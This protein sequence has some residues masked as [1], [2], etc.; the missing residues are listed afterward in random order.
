MKILLPLTN[1]NFYDGVFVG[2]YREKFADYVTKI[3][4]TGNSS[5]LPSLETRKDVITALTE[6]YI[7]QA[8]EQPNGVQ[9][10][11]LANWLLI[12]DLTNNH[13]DKVTLTEYPF[14][15]NRQLR[16]RYRREMANE[17]LQYTLTEQEYLEG[18]KESRYID[19]EQYK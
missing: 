12:E 1:V 17:R 3:L 19:E 4:A 7:I 16:G 2:E 13:P 8:R 5:A 18:K 10:Q 15:T 9:I 11:R 6:A 14:M